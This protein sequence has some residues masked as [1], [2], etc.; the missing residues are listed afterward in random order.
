MHLR[1]GVE[2]RLGPVKFCLCIARIV[3]KVVAGYCEWTNVLSS[4]F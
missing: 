3:H 2:Q 1:I 4:C